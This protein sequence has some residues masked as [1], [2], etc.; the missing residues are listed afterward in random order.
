MT[1]TSA[2]STSFAAFAVWGS[3][4]TAS[5]GCG[6][7][8]NPTH[9]HTEKVGGKVC[10]EN[11]NYRITAGDDNTVNIYNKHTGESY[12]ASGD[13]H[14]SVDGKHVFDFWGTTTL[15]LDDGTKVTI[16]TT[17]WAANP[18]MTLSSKVTITNGDYGVQIT[19]VDTN[20]TGD[21]NFDETTRFGG[22]LD[23]VVGDGNKL[24][25]NPFGAGFLGVDSRGKLRPVDQQYIN[26]TDLEKGGAMQTRYAQ[27]FEKMI[28]LMAIS[29]VGGFLAG[30][31]W[32]QRHDDGGS[33]DRNP[34]PADRP[35]DD[36]S[37]FV[38]VMTRSNQA[39]SWFV[40]G[41]SWNG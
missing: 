28:G 8:S 24:Y 12:E 1:T 15:S 36:N 30:L 31:A 20:K 19:G 16:Q 3:S 34:R 21:L 23:A 2:T 27:A 37:A 33:P 40:A 5:S 26:E 32:A 4:S 22:L 38:M 18:N 13:P 25:E 9:A 6:T 29:F 39:L 14:M 10:F 41:A 7:V 11:D 35:T 17:P